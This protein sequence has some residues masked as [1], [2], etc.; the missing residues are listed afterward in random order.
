MSRHA[1]ALLLVGFGLVELLA[2]PATAADAKWHKVDTFKGKGSKHTET[3]TIPDKEWK[4][5]WKAAGKG[6]FQI[7][8]HE[9]SGDLKDVVAATT[10]PSTDSSVMR[11]AGKFYL[12]INST[13]EF[14]VTVE[15]KH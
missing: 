3:F 8:L 6:V 15:T 4:V 14:E 7:Y 2:M 12:M 9:E 5:S 13:V 11:G 1:A 10:A